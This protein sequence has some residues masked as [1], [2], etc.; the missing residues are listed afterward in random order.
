[1]TVN[2]VT[3]TGNLTRDPELKPM[4]STE[5]LEFSIA[6]NDRLRNQQTGDYEDRPSYFDCTVFGKRGQSLA[7]FL[8]KGMK[9]SLQGKLRQDRWQKDGKNCSKVYVVC[10]EIE[11]M[12]QSQ[13][14][15]Q[16]PREEYGDYYSDEIPF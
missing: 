15:K 9:V 16:K 6:V 12:S 13:K 1:M 5:K 11:F 3:L 7:R 8:S 4:G 10:D 2:T 14:P